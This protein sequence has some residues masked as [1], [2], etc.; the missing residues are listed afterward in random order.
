MI[1]PAV[2]RAIDVV[3]GL[4]LSILLAPVWLPAALAVKLTSPGPM[5]FIQM[6]GGR[7]G[8]PFPFY[9]F[10]TMR[11]DH[12][13][14]PSEVVPLSHAAIT[15]VGRLL[16]RT[17]IDELPQLM[18][19]IKGE[20]SLVGPR[21]TLLEQVAGYDAFQRRRLQVR[22]GCTGLAQV[23]G[24]AEIP[25]SERIKYAVYYVEHFGPALDLHILLKTLLV[26]VLGERRFTRPF[27]QSPFAQ[28][29]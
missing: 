10:R 22:P 25:W 2:K 21:P 28:T 9:K 4:V 5:L 12:V 17:K 23:N 3:A 7:H 26:I 16:R 18:N 13:H 19:V 11:V 6:R 8:R 15:P 29:R 20:V 27:E 14:D 24:N 1:Y